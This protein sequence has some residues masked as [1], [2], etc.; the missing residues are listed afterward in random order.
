[1]IDKSEKCN[2]ELEHV[3]WWVKD[4]STWK[5]IDTIFNLKQERKCVECL[6]LHRCKFAD[7]VIRI[8]MRRDDLIFKR[9]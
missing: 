3:K 7:D 2:E 8:I 4:N 1:M 5:T 9:K 6:I